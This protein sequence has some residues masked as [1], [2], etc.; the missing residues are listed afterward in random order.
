MTTTKT[1]YELRNLVYQPLL[2]TCILTKGYVFST[3]ERKAGAWFKREMKEVWGG[4]KPFLNGSSACPEFWVS[5]VDAEELEEVQALPE[6]IYGDAPPE[7]TFPS[8]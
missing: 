7:V 6:V 5:E 4:G 8:T 3:S 1:L 2:G